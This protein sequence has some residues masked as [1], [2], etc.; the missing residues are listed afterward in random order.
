[1]TVFQ[2]PYTPAYTPKHM[3]AIWQNGAIAKEMVASL[4]PL[5]WYKEAVLNVAAPTGNIAP[6]GRPVVPE[7]KV[8]KAISLSKS[9]ASGAS[10]AWLCS[11]AAIKSVVPLGVGN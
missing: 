2:R 4:R 7:V 6:L 1:M 10:M 3:P 8:I 5:A 11:S 9:T